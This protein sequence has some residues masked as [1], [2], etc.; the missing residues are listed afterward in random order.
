[1][2]SHLTKEIDK[3]FDGM[4]ERGVIDP[5]TCI[6]PWSAP[7]VL[8]TKKDGSYRFCID[9][10]KLNSNT[11]KNAYPLPRI[12]ESLDQ[13]NGSS[14]FSTL[15]LCSGYWQVEM[16]QED[17]SKTAFLTRRG[18]F[19]FNVMPFGLCCAQTTFERLMERVLAGLHWDI[20]LVHL[21]DIIVTGKTFE[22]MLSNL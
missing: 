12:D 4:L 21:D 2:P 8:V 15:D 9:Y 3:H 13:L 16:D 17:K 10:R 6:R 22:E 19:L 5:Y 14:S 1:M 18:L 20:F 7:V 11:I